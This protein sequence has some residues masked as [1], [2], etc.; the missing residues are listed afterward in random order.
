MFKLTVSPSSAACPRSP[1]GILATV[2][3]A[4]LMSACGGGGGG[5]TPTPPPAPTPVPTPT[6]TPI[7]VQA[8]AAMQGIWQSA[9]GAAAT[10]STIVLPDGQFW[11][12]ISGTSGTTTTTRLVK[13]SF[14]AQTVGFG[15]SGKSYT[16]GTSTVD[17]V[18]ATATVLEKSSFS[19]T[20][21]GNGQSEPFALAYQ[22]RYDTPVILPNFAGAWSASLGPGTV[23]WTVGSTGAITGTRTTGCT[24][25]G[26]LSLR[27]EAKAVADVAITES[28]PAVT[29][30]S[31]V[32]IKTV[33]G[34]GIT[35][36][37]TTAGDAQAVV[38]SLR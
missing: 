37:L 38:L 15:C 26:Q 30:L 23:N 4:A 27:R 7:P 12:V 33:D 19:G 25:S 34:A 28:C 31:G 35:M 29:Q 14:T 20:I 24:Y 5:D 18:S 9:T 3:T 32:A 11:S 10:S 22:A 8:V 13:A 16:L 36:M 21:S 2:L 1:V 6:P 17:S